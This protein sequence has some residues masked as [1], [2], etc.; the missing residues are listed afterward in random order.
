MFYCTLMFIGAVVAPTNP[1]LTVA[2]VFHLL[3][4]SNPCVTFAVE[5][6]RGKKT[7]RAIPPA[8]AGGR[9]GPTGHQP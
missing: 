6:T 2:E 7:F 5:D 3:A 8:P 4:L 1:S 9:S